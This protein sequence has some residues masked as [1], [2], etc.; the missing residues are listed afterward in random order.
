MP[1]E[2]ARDV[3]WY[4]MPYGGIFGYAPPPNFSNLLC[5]LDI[6]FDAEALWSSRLSATW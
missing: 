4:L 2:S 5:A 3:E 1:G 6:P